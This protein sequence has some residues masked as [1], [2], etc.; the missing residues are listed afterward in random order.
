VNI[1]YEKIVG[2]A[3]C[4]GI[5]EAHA[6]SILDAMEVPS[7]YGFERII[8][9]RNPWGDG[10]WTGRYSDGS[11]AWT[12]D[13]KELT[14]LK[15]EDDGA[16]WMELS[17]FAAYFACSAVCFLAP[18]SRSDEGR[19]P[20]IDSRGNADQFSLHLQAQSQTLLA[21]NRWNFS[22][23]ICDL[24]N[25]DLFTMDSDHRRCGCM[26]TVPTTCQMFITMDSWW[27]E[28]GLEESS[29]MADFAWCVLLLDPRKRK[30]VGRNKPGYR[31][32]DL[33]WSVRHEGGPFADQLTV[34]TDEMEVPEGQY[35]MVIHF[36]P[37]SCVD[38]LPRKVVCIV[39]ATAPGVQ[40]KPLTE[41]RG[42]MGVEDSMVIDDVDT[43]TDEESDTAKVPFLC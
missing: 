32:L 5:V 4:S 3:G 13:A 30:I 31:W 26:M 2:Q 37:Q 18:G 20:C 22:R 39:C 38:D 25:T 19:T 12:E 14:E 43:S 10:E 29:G 41:G 9:L 1:L 35:L 11:S 36:S 6:Y 15:Q 40:L 33:E 34:S 42:F 17:D 24:E 28:L 7:I 27:E 23:Y 21:H 16:F 8:K